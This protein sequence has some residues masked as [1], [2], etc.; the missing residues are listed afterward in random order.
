[1]TDVE[2]HLHRARCERDMAYRSADECVADAHMRLS[3][4]HLQ[5]A[6]LLQEVQRSPVANIIPL[7]TEADRLSARLASPADR[8]IELPA[9]AVSA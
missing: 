8:L 2:Y 1:M 7:R 4:L 5:R 9:S 6:M 3:A